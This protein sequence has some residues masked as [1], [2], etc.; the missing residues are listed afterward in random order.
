MNA[1]RNTDGNLNVNTNWNPGNHNPNV[2]GRSEIVS[3]FIEAGGWIFSILPA[4]F[5][6]PAGFAEERC[7]FCLQEHQY[8]W[9]LEAK[10][11]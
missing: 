5:L 2:G 8:L 1:N 10:F 6:F 9:Q 7:I 3:C 11:L 4:A